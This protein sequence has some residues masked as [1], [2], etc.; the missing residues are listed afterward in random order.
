MDDLAILRN[1]LFFYSET[2]IVGFDD[3]FYERNID[4]QVCIADFD[5]FVHEQLGLVL[6]LIS[7]TACHIIKA[8]TS[9]DD[10]LHYVLNVWLVL[11]KL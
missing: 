1:R 11:R 4:W 6:V 10:E 3:L 5:T 2:D 8:E 7:V 9:G